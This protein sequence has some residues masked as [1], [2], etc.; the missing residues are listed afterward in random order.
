MKKLLLCA[1]ALYSIH[2]NVHAQDMNINISNEW[3][4]P[5]LIE[6]RPGS[7]YLQIENTGNA[8]DKLVSVSSTVSPRIEIHEHTMKDGVMKMSKV[9]F[10]EIKAS[11]NV[12]LSP[13]GY[14][15]MIFD[16]TSKYDIGD[17][18]D[19]TLNFENAGSI[20]KTFKV[21]MQQP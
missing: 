13:G 16:A 7:A 21:M 15:L 17:H 3:A 4:R 2:L 8:N 20:T 9:D 5:I 6:G 10:I 11:S 14:H 12:K 19:L 18:I 1:L